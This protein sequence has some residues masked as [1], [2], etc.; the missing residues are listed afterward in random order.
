MSPL[1]RS[2][3]D[4]AEAHGGLLETRLTVVEDRLRLL[5]AQRAADPQDAPGAALDRPPADTASTGVWDLEQ[6]GDGDPLVHLVREFG[7]SPAETD[8]LV[9][10]VLP[11][12]N[13]V[14]GAAYRMLSG[15][16]SSRPTVALAL[17]VLGIPAA[18]GTARGLLRASS[19]L[20]RGGLITYENPG[21]THLE[22][23][24]RVPDRVVGHLLGDWE[25]AVAYTCGPHLQALGQGAGPADP[26]AL[27]ALKACLTE[28]T[29][30]AGRGSSVYVQE[31]TSGL[32]LPA[33]CAALR[34]AGRTPLVVNPE[35]LEH[36]PDDFTDTVVREARL[37]HGAAVV[38]VF[39][40]PDAREAPAL[41]RLL[42]GLAGAPLL[43]V[44]Y[45]SGAWDA[46]AWGGTPT[47][48]L[49]LTRACAAPAP[50]VS[51]PRPPLGE[52]LC[53]TAAPALDRARRHAARHARILSPDGARQISRG[54]ALR[55][56]GRLARHVQPSVKWDDLVLPPPV[57]ERL[58]A[59]TY[60]IRHRQ[61]V[62]DA[63]QL[64]RGGGRGWGAAALFAGES[65][66][67]KT[68]AA[69]AVAAE[70][71]VDLYIVSLSTVVSKYIGETEKNLER[72]FSAAESLGGVLL[73]DEADSMFAKR[74]AVRDANDRYANM[75]SAYLLQRLESFDGLAVL[76]T[77][78]RSNM[79]SAFTRRFDEVIEFQSPEPEVRARLWR[80]FLGAERADICDIDHL[81]ARFGL[82]G[83]SIRAAVE[84]A[85]FAA[86]AEDRDVSMRDLLKGVEVEYRKLGRLFDDL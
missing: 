13:A 84:T 51:P 41:R 11:E 44:L 45:G 24:M 59:L 5:Y 54:C 63:W 7:L 40:E 39:V 47:V 79:D 21:S 55:D 69:E 16:N 58:Q 76:T 50:Q 62:L 30:G 68:M 57:R 26:A 32:A 75:Q 18:E 42:T 81:A 65:G 12:L 49:D 86:A 78:L 67:G 20:L 77:N 29:D 82:A 23:L 60:R 31:D 61:R 73:F 25:D 19:A 52:R 74:G 35:E 72:V 4:G 33:A 28:H 53:A 64:R 38:P 36:A 6:Y 8:L 34:E 10:A 22:R 56:L 80:A 48:L 9:C 37:L 2:P 15:A 85:A 70:L 66:T 1:L 43:T 3:A 27:A 46:E 71:G 83:G 17:E 14:C